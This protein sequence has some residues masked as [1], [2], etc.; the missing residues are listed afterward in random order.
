VT[1]RKPLTS[2][3]LQKIYSA[4]PFSYDFEDIL[5]WESP[6]TLPI[7]PPNI[8]SLS[9]EA[10]RINAARIAMNLIKEIEATR[11]A[12]TPGLETYLTE[13]YLSIKHLH[14]DL[15]NHDYAKKKFLLVLYN[16]ID[17]KTPHSLNRYMAKHLYTTSNDDIALNV[18]NIANELVEDGQNFYWF[19][20]RVWPTATVRSF[21]FS[22]S[23]RDNHRDLQRTSL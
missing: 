8:A 9:T 10:L 5:S 13:N 21:Q 23:R 6:C 16:E 19:G 2:A 4:E 15:T 14:P 1:S 3:E 11:P 7:V 12:D 22:L 17:K 20:A 18:E